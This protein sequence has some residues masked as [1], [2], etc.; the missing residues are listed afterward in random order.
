MCIFGTGTLE[1]T[2]N[3]G[4][5]V[6][7]YFLVLHLFHCNFC[8]NTEQILKYPSKITPPPPPPCYAVTLSAVVMLAAAVQQLADMFEA[9]QY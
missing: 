1:V 4:C 8:S 6:V 7:K 3:C 9:V 5:Y 2:V